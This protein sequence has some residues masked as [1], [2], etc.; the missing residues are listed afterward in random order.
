MSFKAV[1]EF[2]SKPKSVFDD[3]QAPKG[4]LNGAQNRSKTGL[5]AQGPP[6]GCPRPAQR[7]WGGFWK[8]FWA[9][10]GPPEG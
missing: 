3:F 10:F 5:G 1:L 4:R 7:L 2:S 6:R 9:N 8:L